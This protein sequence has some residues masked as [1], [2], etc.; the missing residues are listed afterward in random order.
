M[1]VKIEWKDGSIFHQ[2]DAELKHTRN[3]NGMCMHNGQVLVFPNLKEGAEVVS[4]VNGKWAKVGRVT[5]GMIF[6]GPGLS[7]SEMNEELFK[8]KKLEEIMVKF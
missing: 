7:Y 6:L 5:R 3:N 8:G 1:K 4:P 2:A